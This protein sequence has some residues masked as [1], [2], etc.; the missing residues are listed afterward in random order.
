MKQNILIASRG[1]VIMFMSRTLKPCLLRQGVL[2]HPKHE[3]LSQ[4]THFS[5]WWHIVFLMFS[6]LIVPGVSASLFDSLEELTLRPCSLDSETSANTS[7]IRSTFNIVPFTDECTLF[8]D[9]YPF[10]QTIL[11]KS[12]LD[13]NISTHYGLIYRSSAGDTNADY[14]FVLGKNPA[15]T[16]YL[17]S[18]LANYTSYEHYFSDNLALFSEEGAPVVF[19]STASENACIVDAFVDEHTSISFLNYSSSCIDAVTAYFP[20]CINQ[21]ISFS[22]FS[23]SKGCSDGA[24]L[25]SGEGTIQQPAS[26]AT[27]S[28]AGSTSG[29]SGS[30]GGGGG[31]G[32]S[33]STGASSF[34]TD[35]SSASAGEAEEQESSSESS[36]QSDTGVMEEESN[37]FSRLIAFIKNFLKNIFT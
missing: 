29:S 12:T 22:F 9:E 16:S 35:A 14:F 24:C 15:A 28:S 17:I 26:S 20:R 1:I 33:S 6:F 10:S 2:E 5:A 31:G 21:R 18:L 23:C 25:A 13:F 7:L 27:A 30:G 37:A 3:C 8:V 11:E 4:T 34:N 19:S 36:T 32:G